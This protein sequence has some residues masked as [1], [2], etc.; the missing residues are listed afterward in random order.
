M[1]EIFVLQ[2]YIFRVNNNLLS[3]LEQNRAIISSSCS[4]ETRLGKISGFS[5]E[6]SLF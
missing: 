2:K 6:I 5:T 4:E 3:W 1:F